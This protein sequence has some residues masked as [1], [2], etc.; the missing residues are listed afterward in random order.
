MMPG[1]RTIGSSSAATTGAGN[2]S[3]SDLAV[4]CK[5]EIQFSRSRAVL[6]SALSSPS[7]PISSALRVACPRE[8]P[9]LHKWTCSI[10]YADGAKSVHGTHTE[11]AFFAARVRAIQ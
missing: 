4:A 6:H 5:K 1:D 3:F 2:G 7:C 8:A 11:H 10:I 9:E